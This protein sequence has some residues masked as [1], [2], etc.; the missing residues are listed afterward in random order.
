MSIESNLFLGI[1]IGGTKIQL[2]AADEALNEIDHITFKVGEVKEA[3]II[4]KKLSDEIEE[5]IS[6]HEFQSIGVGFGGPVDSNTGQIYDSFHVNGWRNINLRNWIS[7]QSKLPVFVENDA[8]VAALGEAVYG[9]GKPYGRVFY[10]T[11]GSGVGGGYVVNGIIYHGKGPSEI[12]A[13]HLCLDKQGKTLESSCSG[14]ALNGKLRDYTAQEPKSIL[15]RL[16]KAQQADETKCMLEAIDAG[17]KGVEQIFQETMDDLALGL[18]HIVHLLNPEI[19][20]IGG[21]LSLIGERLIEVL[22]Q[23]LPS[24]LMPTLRNSL[25]MLCLSELKE[26]SV[27]YG[28]IQLAKSKL[29]RVN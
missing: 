3:V 16:V 20:I 5:L 14:W 28:A 25:P 9:A 24:Y 8:N 11:L 29:Q 1:E 17:D 2:L 13:G 27:P 7:N 21:G 4:Q 15:A 19:I 18:S 26:N 22:K 6:R 12:E 23:R 10:L